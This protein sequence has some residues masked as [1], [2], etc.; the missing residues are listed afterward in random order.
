[1]CRLTVAPRPKHQGKGNKKS[2]TLAEAA[3]EDVVMLDTEGDGGKD[4]C[5]EDKGGDGAEAGDEELDEEELELVEGIRAYSV[6]CIQEI[7]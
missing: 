1:M 2:I 3:D 6:V 4:I 7:L 5:E